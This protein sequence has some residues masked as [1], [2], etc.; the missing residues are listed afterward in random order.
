M[1]ARAA[2]IA[3]AAAQ[4]ADDKKAT[5][6]RVFDVTGLSDVCDAICVC[7]AS[8]PRLAASVVDEVQDRVRETLGVSPI[9]EEGGGDGRWELLDYGCAVVHVMS[10][11]ARDYYRLERLWGDAPSLDVGL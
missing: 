3:R 8:N 1:S 4:A 6:V 5:D 10:P 11:E 2:D 7:T 9:S